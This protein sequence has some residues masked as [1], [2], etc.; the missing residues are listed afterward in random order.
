MNNTR[1]NISDNE[2]ADLA[3][4]ENPANDNEESACRISSQESGN[5][6]L[7]RHD[8]KMFR[9]LSS[10]PQKAGVPLN[11]LRRLVLKELADNALD[12]G[13]RVTIREDAGH[14]TIEDNG[15]GIPGAPEEIAELFSI[16][17]PMI[18][19]K[20]PRLP[21]RG[22]LGNG[23]R[24]VAGAVLASQGALVVTTHNM[25]RNYCG[26][27]GPSRTVTAASPQRSTRPT[28]AS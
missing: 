22:A 5:L 1:P 9:S 20:L 17:R 16:N 28:G 21:T 18:S 23:L 11:L 25:R 8:W 24:V 2:P 10:L 19:T 27:H 12:A 4:F 6:K 7:M 13:G 3:D 26:G 14:Y 15:L